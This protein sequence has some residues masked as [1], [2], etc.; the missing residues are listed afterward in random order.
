MQ[1]LVTFAQQQ[2]FGTW[3]HVVTSNRLRVV[4]DV[5]IGFIGQVSQIFFTRLSLCKAS[6]Y[7][8]LEPDVRLKV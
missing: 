4:C 7:R 3:R 1:L 5:A 6:T 8:N 2:N